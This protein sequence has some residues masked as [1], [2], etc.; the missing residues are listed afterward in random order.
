[1]KILALDPATTT[2]YC[3]DKGSGILKLGILGKT[4]RPEKLLAFYNYLHDTIKKEEITHLV[5][6]RPGGSHY[7]SLVSHASL[8]AM[9]L[10]V[11]QM[12]ELYYLGYSASSIKKYITGKGN[13]SKQEVI[14]AVK[15]LGYDPYDDNEA[16]AIAIFLL[17]KNDLT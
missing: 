3:S 5:Y 10:L 17:A 12:R 16:D 4:E 8:E 9:I 14:D 6:E 7:N 13:A 2:G 11:C 1:M 15:K